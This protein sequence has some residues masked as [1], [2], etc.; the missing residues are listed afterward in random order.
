[1]LAE[2]KKADLVHVA[3]DSSM[4]DSLGIHSLLKVSKTLPEVGDRVIVVG[5]PEGQER[6]VSEGIVDVVSAAFTG[7]SAARRESDGIAGTG[8]R[9][10][11]HTGFWGCGAF[12]GNRTLMTILQAFA[13]DLADVDVVFWAS[14]PAGVQLAEDARSVYERIRDTTSTVSE[15]LDHLVGQKFQW[16]VSDGN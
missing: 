4:M 8:S 11:I 13:G 9:T 16:G 14:G 2:D 1:M 3:V 15:I 12:G 10:V 5:N 6:T 7:F